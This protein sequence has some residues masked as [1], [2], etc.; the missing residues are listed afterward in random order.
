MGANETFV[1]Y[2]SYMYID[3]TVSVSP[4]EVEAKYVAR[5]KD[6]VDDD[7]I[8][9]DIKLQANRRRHFHVISEGHH[10]GPSKITMPHHFHMSYLEV[11]P[12]GTAGLHAHALPEVFIALT[13]RFQIIF[14]DHGEHA[15]EL[16]PY[17]TISVP[18]GVMRNFKNVGNVN[19]L[20]M[21]IYDGPGEVLGKIFMNREAADD[22][23]RTRP[24]LA[25]QFIRP[26]DWGAAAET[27]VPNAQGSGA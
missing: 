22:L 4:E 2:P 14:G 26:E 15:I 3:K 8:F 16:E 24:Q 20:L 6:L 7:D 23:I 12:G 13:G 9:P 27:A 10:I 18:V 25:Q 1:R 21:V 5:F 17:D 11:P 19:G